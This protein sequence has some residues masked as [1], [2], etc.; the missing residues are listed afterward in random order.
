M[1]IKTEKLESLYTVDENAKSVGNYVE[2][3]QRIEKIV[4]HVIQQTCF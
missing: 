3:P 1:L 2:V 4:P